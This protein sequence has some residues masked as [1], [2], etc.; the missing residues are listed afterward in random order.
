MELNSEFT[1]EFEWLSLE[2][3]NPMEQETF[4]EI[5]I[6]VGDT[7]VTEVKDLQ[8]KTVR[9]CIRVSAY[10][11]AVWLVSNWWRLRWEP[12][13]NGTDW[14]LAHQLS[15][16][17][18][19]YSWPGLTIASDGEFVSFQQQPL[20][21]AAVAPVRFLNEVNENI[22]V[23]VFVKTIKEFIDVVLGR[24]RDCGVQTGE[25]LKQWN[26]ILQ[27]EKDEKLYRLR[28]YEALLGME[29]GMATEGT[30]DFI[31]EKSYKTGRGAIEEMMATFRREVTKGIEQAEKLAKKAQP[32]ELEVPG[33][34][35][36]HLQKYSFERLE[37]WQKAEKVAEFIRK[38]WG[39]VDGPISNKYLAETCG[40]P[41]KYL[42]E[43]FQI[44]SFP[45]SIGFNGNGSGATAVYLDKNWITG[46][47][48]AL[49]RIIG[50]VFYTSEEDDHWFPATDVKTVRQK[51]QRAFAQEFLCP[52]R[53]IESFFGK[54]QY[55][56]DN[57]EELANIFQVS[58]LCV[59]T[60]L[61]N[62]GKLGREVL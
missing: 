61:V 49:A 18:G 30:I 14:K 13:M 37:P 31:R 32:F 17:G 60:T 38:K 11:M 20:K 36:E 10:H 59:K 24:L 23:E 16:A 3:N 52:Y 1:I 5:M 19:G 40:L 55:T 15:A 44:E 41:V 48:F 26:K 2:M 45:G 7:V 50:D 6:S 35:R 56:E 54:K 21:K 8:A 25:L 42:I 9:E 27:E 22:P 43:D 4:A 62:R 34:F 33:S 57:I 28:K 12:E 51:F 39:I 46:R 53:E 58:P 47:R 29:P